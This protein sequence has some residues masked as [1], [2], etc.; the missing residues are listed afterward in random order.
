MFFNCKWTGIDRDAQDFPVREPSSSSA[1]YREGQ[2]LGHDTTNGHRR[3]AEKE[4]LVQAWDQDRASKADDPCS[5]GRSRHVGV[6][7]IGYGRPNLR[8]RTFIVKFDSVFVVKIRVVE[9]ST[10]E[11]LDFAN[12]S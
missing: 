11:L 7:S 5:Q 10:S 2:E 3:V 6:I 4:K 1:T 8:V 12:P 9:L